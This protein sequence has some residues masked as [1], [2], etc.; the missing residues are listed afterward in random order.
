MKCTCHFY[1]GRIISKFSNGVKFGK[2]TWNLWSHLQGLSMWMDMQA[3]ALKI[4][5][6]FVLFCWSKIKFLDFPA[7]YFTEATKAIASMPHGHCLGAFTKLLFPPLPRRKCLFALFALLPL[8]SKQS[9][10]AWT[11]IKMDANVTDFFLFFWRFL[12][13]ILSLHVQPH[14]ESLSVGFRHLRK[15][16]PTINDK[17]RWCLSGQY[18]IVISVPLNKERNKVVFTRTSY[19]PLWVMQS[20]S[21]YSLC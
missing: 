13:C 11:S 16:N 9:I 19:T 14:V 8:P 18:F 12:H 4:V 10:Q 3:H 6:H 20:T 1:N 2:S 7:W 17:I 21:P 15:T 5:Y